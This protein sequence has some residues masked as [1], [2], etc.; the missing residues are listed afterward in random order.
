[1]GI[2]LSFLEVFS[3]D[4]SPFLV[5]IHEE[6]LNDELLADGHITTF[7]VSLSICSLK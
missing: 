7:K 1:M 3:I 6:L 5:F 2:L 4:P